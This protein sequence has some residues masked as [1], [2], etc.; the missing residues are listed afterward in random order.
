[1][2]KNEKCMYRYKNMFNYS[3]RLYKTKDTREKFKYRGR[4]SAEYRQNS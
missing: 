1:M 2:R 4:R 3:N